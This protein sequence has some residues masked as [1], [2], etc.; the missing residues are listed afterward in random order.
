[1][2]VIDANISEQA[3]E[4]QRLFLQYYAELANLE[5]IYASRRVNCYWLS[6]ERN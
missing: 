5:K 6:M 2:D 1:M 3:G 4:I